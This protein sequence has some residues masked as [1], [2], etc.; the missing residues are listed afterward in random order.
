MLPTSGGLGTMKN[1]SRT[2][3]Q[4]NCIAL[5]LWVSIM[6]P[7]FLILFCYGGIVLREHWEMEGS[8]FN[9]KAMLYF[10]F[11]GVIL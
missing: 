11:L 9:L 10:I 2:L 3:R 1:D 7:V 6:A 4:T 5:C 8:L